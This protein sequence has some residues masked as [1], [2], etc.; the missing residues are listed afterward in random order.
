MQKSFKFLAAAGATALAL[1]AGTSNTANANFIAYICDDLQCSGGGD[2][3]V[4]DVDGDGVINFSFATAGMTVVVNTAQSKPALGSAAAPQMDITFTAT[5]TGVAGPVFILASDTGFTGVGPVSGALD[6][7][8]TG[9]SGVRGRIWGANNN[10]N[11]SP[12]PGPLLVTTPI[13]TTTPF[14]AT[15]T[16]PVVGVAANP[17]VLTI[18]VD[19]TRT[20]AGTT[21][22]D[23]NV[24]VTTVPEP[25]TL[26]LLGIAL[27][28]LGF[29][30]R[31]AQA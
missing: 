11:P 13:L 21:T 12:T 27:V 16:G 20:T 7:N 22:G 25:A 1:T 31:R 5:S 28:G 3:I 2:M 15:L 29:L 9:S 14:S 23:L 19:I 4:T 17:Y 30:R 6:G 18:G 8:F 24:R 10:V 26:G